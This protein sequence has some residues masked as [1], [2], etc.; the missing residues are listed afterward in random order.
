M[1]KSVYGSAVFMLMFFAPNAGIAGQEDGS[2][3]YYI[4]EINFDITGRTTKYALLR[5][6]EIQTGYEITGKAALLEYIERRRQML[7]NRRELRSADIDFVLAEPDGYNRIPVDLVIRTVDTR[8]F[9]IVPEPKYSSNTGWAPALRVRDF[10]FLGSMTPLGIDITYRYHDGGDVTYPRGNISLALGMEIPF[11]AMGFDW[12]FSTENVFSY[13]FSEPFSYGNTSGI[14]VDIPFRNTVFTFG[15]DQG[16]YFGAEYDDWRKYIYNVNFEDI[17]YGSSASYAEWE[18]PLPVENGF[19]GVLKYKPSVYGKGNY[20]FRG[21]D[22]REREG[23]FLNISQKLGFDKVDW[24]GNYRRG[25]DIYIE[26]NNEYGFFLGEWINSVTLNAAAHFIPA[27]FLGISLRGR[28][29]RWLYGAGFDNSERWGAA[30]MIRGVDDGSLAAESMLLFNFDFTFHVFNFIF[31]EY[32]NSEKLRLIDFELQASPVI[33]IALVNGKKVDSKRNIV[34]DITYHPDDWIVSGGL[35]LFF[36]PLAFRSIYLC[37]SAVWN[38]DKL[39]KEGLMPEKDDL[40]LYI[41]FGH[42][43]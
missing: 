36:F 30:A 24:V 10:N 7:I 33:D 22:L 29:T 18:I 43:Y 4:R 5:A 25:A 40:E 32:F 16:V 34:R 38:L 2:A 13:Y 17:W 14:S 26:N 15:V 42:H 1:K 12:N 21:E 39:F 11:R 31:S 20:S 19:L 8:N 41:G 3:V 35:E 9:I 28:F 37:A 27:D 23:Y 6:C